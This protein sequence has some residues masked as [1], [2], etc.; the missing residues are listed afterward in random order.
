[1]MKIKVSEKLR[2]VYSASA[3]AFFKLVAQPY[4][5]ER[6]KKMLERTRLDIVHYALTTGPGRAERAREKERARERAR[7]QYID[8]QARSIN[9]FANEQKIARG[10]RPR[11]FISSL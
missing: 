11:K 8:N 1:M 7:R 4:I 3:M 6:L 10:E 2:G 9:A 5:D